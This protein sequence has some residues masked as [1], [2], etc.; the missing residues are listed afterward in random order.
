MDSAR[1]EWCVGAF[2]AKA[3]VERASAKNS[4]IV[5]SIA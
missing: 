4:T 3:A 5:F 1:M 2:A